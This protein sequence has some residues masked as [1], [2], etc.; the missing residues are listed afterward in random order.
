MRRPE[1]ESPRVRQARRELAASYEEQRRA[2]RGFHHEEQEERQPLPRA[3]IQ[4]RPK[5]IPIYKRPLV[6]IPTAL[7]LLGVGGVAFKAEVNM[8][9]RVTIVAGEGKSSS[10]EGIYKEIQESMDDK[11]RAK[12]I[13]EILVEYNSPMA[14]QGLGKF[15]VEKGHEYDIDPAVAVAIAG[16]DSTFG[17]HLSVSNNH[18]P[19]N[20]GNTDSC[21]TCQKYGTWKEGLEAGFQ[22]F[23]NQYLGYA[24]VVGQLSI[25]GYK[26][27]GQKPQGPIWASSQKDSPPFYGDWNENVTKFLGEFYGM[28]KQEDYIRYPFRM[29]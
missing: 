23:N 2:L 5:E 18:N 1:E 7:A 25:G 17:R 13:E 6:V 3:S 4:R 10:A 28:G 22:T 21:P 16:A 24:E 15:M 19:M 11:E 29:D 20:V 27:M 14:G 9:G 12:R 8:P 26:S